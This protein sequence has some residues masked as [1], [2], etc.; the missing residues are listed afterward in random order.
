MGG[1][2]NTKCLL[3]TCDNLINFDK[4]VQAK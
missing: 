4:H 3:K 2:T 1:Y